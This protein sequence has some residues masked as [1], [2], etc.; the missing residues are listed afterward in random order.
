MTRRRPTLAALAL[1]GAILLASDVRP[2]HAAW[3]NT[4]NLV[5]DSSVSERPNSIT[6]DG[7]GGAFIV[8]SLAG[9]QPLRIQRLD[10]TGA[11]LWGNQ[12]VSVNPGGLA[13]SFGL[14]TPDSAGGAWVVWYDTRTTGTGRGMYIQRFDAAG[15]PQLTSGGLRIFNRAVTSVASATTSAG[16]LLVAHMTN[17]DSLRLQRLAING[18]PEFAGEGILVA[19]SASSFSSAPQLFADGEGAVIAYNR[20]MP[21]VGGGNSTQ[22]LWANRYNSAGAAQ[23]GAAGVAVMSLNSAAVLVARSVWNG[24]SLYLSWQQAPTSYNFVESYPI[25]AQR[26]SSG[27]APQWAANGVT[28]LTPVTSSPFFQ[29]QNH[30]QQIVYESA[31]SSVIIAW[32]DSRHYFQP[33]PNTFLHGDDLYAQRLSS[34]GAAQWTANGMPIDSTAG[35]LDDLRACASPSGGAYLAYTDFAFGDGDEDVELRRIDVNGATLWSRFLNA[36]NNTGRQR[37]AV[38]SADGEGGALVAWEDDRTAATGPDVYA[39]RRTATS[40]NVFAQTLSVTGPNGGES[41]TTFDVLPIRWTTNYAGGTVRVE[42]RRDGSPPTNLTVLAEPND[43]V[44][45]W[46]ISDNFSGQYKIIVSDFATGVPKDSSD[47]FFTI[48]PALVNTVP[49][50]LGA[51][52]VDAVTG[53]F[54][55]NGILD[56][57]AANA[58]GVTV[59]LG[60]GSAGVWNQ[61][62]LAPVSIALPGARA[63]AAADWDEDGITDLLVTHADGL[64]WLRGLGSGGVGTGGFGAATAL[65]S[66]P[67]LDYQGIAVADMSSDGVL[68]VVTTVPGTDRTLVL[69]QEV[70]GDGAGTGVIG[71]SRQLFVQDRP[72]RV[73]VADVNGDAVPDVL[74]LNR[75]S[76]SVTVHLADGSLPGYSLTSF[77]SPLH[78]AVGDSVRSMALGDFNEDN[79]LDIAVGRVPASGFTSV[80]LGLKTGIVPNGS[81][82]APV[83]YPGG[84]GPVAVTDYDGDG[85]SDVLTASSLLLSAL[86]GD[87]AGAAGDGTFTGTGT[88]TGVLSPTCLQVDDFNRDGTPDLLVVSA[89][90]NQ[91]R[92][93][94]GGCAP[95]VPVALSVSSPAPGDVT[96]ADQRR[97]L[98]WTKGSGNGLTHLDLSRDGGANWEPLARHRAG[99]AASLPIPGPATSNARLRVTDALNPGRSATMPAGF[100]ICRALSEGQV[101]TYA[102]EGVDVTLY[103]MDADGR[104]DAVVNA[105]EFRRGQAGGTFGGTQTLSGVPTDRGLAVVTDFDLDGVPDMIRT[106]T[107]STGIY[108]GRPPGGTGWSGTMDLTQLIPVPSYKL[109][110]GDFDEDGIQDLA[111]VTA[112]NVSAALHVYR[113]LGAGGVGNGQFQFTQSAPLGQV[114]GDLQIADVN[115]DGILD[116]VAADRWAT[117]LSGILVFLGQGSAGHGDGTF[118]SA[119]P[120]LPSKG[121][122]AIGVADLDGDGKPDLVA[123]GPTTLH[124]MKGNGDG[125]FTQVGSAA[126]KGATDLALAD[127]DEDGQIDIALAQYTSDTVRV[128]LRRGSGALQSTSFPTHEAFDV[129]TANGGAPTRIA[130]GD[131]DLDGRPDLAVMTRY[132]RQL[133]IYR[134]TCAVP[135]RGTVTVSSPNGGEVFA[136]GEERV[137]SFSVVDGGMP[138]VD[139]D[140]SF[141][142]GATWRNIARNRQSKNFTWT[143]TGPGTNQALFRARHPGSV[144]RGDVSNAPFLINAPTTDAGDGAGLPEV[145]SFS[146]PRP[147]PSRGPAMFTLALPERSGVRIELFDLSGRR[148]RTLADAEFEAGEHRLIWDGRADDGRPAREGVFFARARAKGLSQERTLVRVR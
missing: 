9:G 18:A 79:A 5:A 4:G 70:A 56:V 80:L 10:A 43:G 41:F 144:L 124:L 82:G 134:Q 110:L 67:G 90:S 16:E 136:Q 96:V 54:D 62:F 36:F 72:E 112:P 75:G 69:L 99:T 47:A 3:S 59:Q 27:G 141:D 52:A 113:G 40:G 93:F 87:G 6:P 102:E 49:L 24:A 13:G 21:G 50:T 125:T 145:A 26:I 83:A 120:S 139:L 61:T 131:L 29:H 76:G 86:H 97:L 123:S 140:V 51:S 38:L 14:V 100:V 37:R 11:R 17:G 147:N 55:E 111:L 94:L 77:S 60:G 95:T 1:L 30:E 7:T 74:T 31:T 118:G 88:I 116:I 57:A 33:A 129:V 127:F 126:G 138:L 119:L 28:V 66:S 19:D 108:R 115:Q 22:L 146:A 137:L 89:S 58:A 103:D 92:V 121:T 135:L 148:V 98:G 20:F 81:F 91:S 48:C 46:A 45:D 107:S 122:D 53:D 8:S 44:K 35:G 85:R 63:L 42:I 39:T 64:Y 133:R 105:R 84:S 78:F 32:L 109:A 101:H 2:A 34:A 104:L 71:G 65:M 128:L 73:A 25:R 106:H 114:S 142:Q 23:W 117:A 143:V 12:G 130:S 132:G 15:A 68:D